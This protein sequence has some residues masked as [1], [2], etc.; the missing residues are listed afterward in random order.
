MI[1]VT[2]AA[3]FIGSHIIRGL[4]RI[5][6]HDI[7]AVDN[8]KQSEKFQNLIE[9]NFDD[10][11]DYNDFLVEVKNHASWLN[12]VEAIFH[13]G[14]FIDRFEHDGQ[15]I[16]KNNYDYSKVL[17]HHCIDKKI[18]FIY[19]SS[20]SVYGKNDEFTEANVERPIH[21]VG[22]SKWLFDQYVQRVMPR[23]DSQVVGLRYFDVYGS[24]EHHKGYMAS[25]VHHFCQQLIKGQSL[26]LYSSPYF[27][28]GEQKRDFIHID[29][30]VNVNLWCWQNPQVTGVFNCGT[31]QAKTFADVAQCLIELNGKGKTEEVILPTRLEDDYRIYT[32]ANIDRLREAGFRDKFTDFKQGLENVFQWHTEV[33]IL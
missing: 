19:A 6:R 31:G 32:K 29:D 7:L 26:S 10:Y 25:V 28:S 1:V 33:G 9:T 16:M 8:L 3:G 18:A 13:Q 4:N 23:V 20:S 30:V 12:G 5:G 24:R 11:M 2:G 15:V 21:I 22:Y 17:L 14:G 27:S